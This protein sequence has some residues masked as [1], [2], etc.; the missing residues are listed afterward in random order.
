MQTVLNTMTFVGELLRVVSAG[1]L[2]I[3]AG[4]MLTEGLVLVPYWRSIKTEAF[5]AWYGENHQ[6]LV[7]FFAPLT[8]IAALT[9]RGAR[10]WALLIRSVQTRP[11]LGRRQRLLEPVHVNHCLEDGP[12]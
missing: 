7:G 3:F 4:A 1:T 6:R 12:R 8:W 10:G 2:G 5:Y 11:A 9:H